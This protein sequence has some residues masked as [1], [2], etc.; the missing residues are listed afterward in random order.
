MMLKWFRKKTTT[1]AFD[2]QLN[3]LY[4]IGIKLK[5]SLNRKHLFEHFSQEEMELDPYIMLLVTLGSEVEMDNKFDF[6]SDDICH[7]DTECIEDHGD[8]Q[9]IV[10][11][12]VQL[13]KGSFKITEIKDYI[14]IDN[15][16]V[17][18]SFNAD[19][20]LFKH[21]LRVEDDWLDLSILSILNSI[22]AKQNLEKKYYYAVLGQDVL[23]G[24]YTEEQV[25]KLNKLITKI[26]FE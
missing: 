2:N 9:R 17:W 22:V 14:D 5:P 26:H 18:I 15:E 8:Y 25:I 11:R 23:I 10:Q 6:I 19:G 13:T 7:L 1:V 21:D 20:E 4:E 3:T 24:F 12:L 16:E